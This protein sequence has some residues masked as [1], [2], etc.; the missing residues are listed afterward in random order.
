MDKEYVK[1]VAK[2]IRNQ[3]LGLTNIDVWNSWGVWKMTSMIY[4]QKAALKLYVNGRLWPHSVIIA[5]DE[6]VDY[7][8]IWL[9]GG[10]E[11]DRRIAYDVD[12]TQL[13]D[14]IDRAIE[15]GNDKDEYDRFCEE[16][17]KKLFRG[18]IW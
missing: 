12:F 16:E 14:I 3:I 15:V 2:E 10:S 17:R 5:L 13:S 18:E 6:G 11:A 7:Y 4:K 9:V 8:E 1:S